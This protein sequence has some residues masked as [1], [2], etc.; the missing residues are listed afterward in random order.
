MLATFHVI[1]VFILRC[2]L[3]GSQRYKF[4]DQNNQINNAQI[5]V[6][7]NDEKTTILQI[8]KGNCLLIVSWHEKKPFQIDDEPSTLFTVGDK[9][10]S[11]LV[12]LCGIPADCQEVKR[13]VIA[14][15]EEYFSTNNIHPSANIIALNLKSITTNRNLVFH[16]LLAPISKYPNRMT[17]PNRFFSY[18]VDAA[19]NIRKCSSISIGYNSDEINEW[20]NN[21]MS[22]Y[23]S[24][25]TTSV[26]YSSFLH[27]LHVLLQS[28]KQYSLIPSNLWILLLCPNVMSSLIDTDFYSE[29]HT[30]NLG[31][32][33]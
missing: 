26:N 28:I 6:L 21:H 25:Q 8:I 4:E 17:I 18:T 31:E 5:G 20:L 23:P 11:T 9:K 16:S 15:N 1:F 27:T 13:L 22:H 30:G 7:R 10:V 33:F 32:H 2:L 14:M 29:S 3:V 24:R 12:G 19:L